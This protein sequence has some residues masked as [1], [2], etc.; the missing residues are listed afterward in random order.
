[1]IR[2]NRKENR[3]TCTDDERNQLFNEQHEILEDVTDLSELK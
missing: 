3:K 2:M 1:M